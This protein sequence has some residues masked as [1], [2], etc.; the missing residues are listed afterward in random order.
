VAAYLKCVGFRIE[1]NAIENRKVSFIFKNSMDLEKS[2]N[3]YVNR[4]ALVDPVR[5]K[6]E[7]DLLRNLINQLK[8]RD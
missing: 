1:S 2:L 3:C 4:E 7:V 8:E 5:Y 6:E